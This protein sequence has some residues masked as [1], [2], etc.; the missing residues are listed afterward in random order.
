MFFTIPEVAKQV[1]LFQSDGLEQGST[2][3][4]RRRLGL[5]RAPVLLC[6]HGREGSASHTASKGLGT[7]QTQM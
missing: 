2:S 6:V 7:N 4:F 1:N 3:S 5:E